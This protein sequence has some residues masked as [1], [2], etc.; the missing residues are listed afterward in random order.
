MLK[1]EFWQVI[2]ATRNEA[3]GDAD[4]H[5][6]T[7]R[8][9]LDALEPQELVTFQHWFDDYYGRANTWALWGAAYVI[10]GGCSDDSFMDFK[11]WL[12]SRGEKVFEAA[13]ADPESLAKVVKPDEDCQVEGFTYAA[14]WAWSEK[15]CQPFKSFPPSPLST[16]AG[17]PTG[18]SWEEDDLDRL[19]PKLT[20]KFSG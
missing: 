3:G 8:T 13:L 7:L 6:E 20:K 12:V 2:D 1:A 11:G 9:R 14:Q 10:G 5:V 19:F 18:E 16:G 17:D 4:Q 15:T